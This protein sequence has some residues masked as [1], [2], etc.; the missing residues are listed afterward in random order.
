[1][2]VK[3]HEKAEGSKI[4]L[5]VSVLREEFSEACEKAYRQNV[6]KINVHGFRKGKAPR[7]MIE[8]LYGENVFYEDAVNIAYPKAYEAAISELDITPVE[9]ADVE[10]LDISAEGF[11]FKATV[12]VKPEVKIS[13]Y[14]G[15]KAPKDE[16]VVE[17]GDITAELTGLQNRNARMVDVSRPVKDGDTVTIDFDGFLDGVPFEGGKAEKFNLKIGSGQFIPGFE[18][19]LI[20]MEL[21]TERDVNVT[22]PEEY[23]AENLAGKPVVFKVALHGVKETELPALDDEFAKD[24]PDFDTLDEFKA[25]ISEKILDAK[26]KSAD[27]AYESL[28]IEQLAEKLEA[29]IPDAMVET[30]LNHIT[31]DYSSRLAAQGMTLENYLSMSGMTPE[32]FRENFKPAALRQVKANLALEAVFKAEKMTITDEE[33]EEEYTRL[34]ELYGLEV[35]KVR[36]YLPVEAM[37]HDLISLKASK[38]IVSKSEALPPEK[39][40]AKKAPKEVKDAPKTAKKTA[41]AEKTAEKKPAA[42]KTAPK[43]DTDKAAKTSGKSE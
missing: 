8:R 35:D 7:R 22:F 5:E 30:Q 15:L 19:Q 26:K 12:A 34:S 38:F 41:A 24:V 3:N 40:T 16:A 17:D 2:V 18:E 23:H 42:K 9:R 1:M 20:G 10:I 14:T 37:K 11:S 32:G 31:E 29:E 6:S 36:G 21:G 33:V 27:Q 13:G 28:L 25:S 43:K 39:K 4:I